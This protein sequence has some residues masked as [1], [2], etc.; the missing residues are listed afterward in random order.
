MP[1]ISSFI[2]YR[3]LRAARDS[4]PGARE[5]YA[6]FEDSVMSE[7][8]LLETMDGPFL[9]THDDVAAV[10]RWVDSQL[11]PSAGSRAAPR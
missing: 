10:R 4:R 3:L 2:G 6:A 1:R 5:A 11:A 7:E 9:L 8:F